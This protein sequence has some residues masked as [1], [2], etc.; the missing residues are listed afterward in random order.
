MFQSQLVRLLF[1]AALTLFITTPA[2]AQTPDLVV[3]TYD[4]FNSEWG[5]GPVVFKR[6]EE[7]CGCTV[8]V[9]A[10]GDSGTPGTVPRGA[11]PVAIHRFSGGRP[12]SF[13]SPD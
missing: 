1:G 4:S 7:H 5:P 9:I 12:D 11:D 3:Y 2:L 8:K 6:F 10:P 13:A